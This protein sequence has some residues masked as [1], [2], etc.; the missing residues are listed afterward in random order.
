MSAERRI[1]N[2]V[3]HISVAL[4]YLT[5]IFGGF[6]TSLPFGLGILLGGLLVTVN[7]HFMCSSLEKALSPPYQINIGIAVAK[8]YLRFVLSVAVISTLTISSYIH[9]VGL[10]IGLSVIVASFMLAAIRE[11]IR[12]FK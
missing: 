5:T 9:P 10:V 6:N 2:F 8:H 11:S 7:F 1:L 3:K 4:C 12:L